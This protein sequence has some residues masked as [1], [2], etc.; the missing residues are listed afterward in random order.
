MFYH[1]SSLKFSAHVPDLNTHIE[2]MQH[3]DDM[4]DGGRDPS[5]I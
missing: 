5:R 2:S 3:A 1:V 4:R